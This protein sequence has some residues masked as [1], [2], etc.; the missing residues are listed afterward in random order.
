VV[1]PVSALRRVFVWLEV[2]QL[3]DQGFSVVKMAVR[4]ERLLDYVVGEGA[5][6]LQFDD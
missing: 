5:T 3:L 2:T 1:K 6:N 4:C